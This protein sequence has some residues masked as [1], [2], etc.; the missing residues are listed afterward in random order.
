MWS[1]F[2]TTDAM[3]NTELSYEFKHVAIHTAV[4]GSHHELCNVKALTYQMEIT[5]VT[6]G[7]RHVIDT[8]SRSVRKCLKHN[9]I[10]CG[11]LTV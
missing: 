11:C 2:G 6:Y 5:S 7:V 9:V 3:L 10:S 1:E 4:H 8:T